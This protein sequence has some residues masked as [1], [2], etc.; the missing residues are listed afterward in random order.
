M[1]KYCSEADKNNI[2]GTNS[3]WLL[4]LCLLEKLLELVDVVVGTSQDLRLYEI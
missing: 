2:K 3:C 4:S 1:L